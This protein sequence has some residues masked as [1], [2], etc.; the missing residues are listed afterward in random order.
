MEEYEDM[1]EYYKQNA[2]II[3]KYSADEAKEMLT[4]QQAIEELH[5][6]GFD[7]FEIT[8]DYKADGEYV[9]D[10][11]VTGSKEQR[12][13]YQTYYSSLV[14]EE[15]WYI[16]MINGFITASPAY[17]NS[18]LYVPVIL[19]E[20]ESILGYDSDTNTFFEIIPNETIAKLKVVNKINAET[21][22]SFTNEIL[23]E[24]L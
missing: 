1:E 18:K 5:K 19:S 24:L 16:I 22:D 11:E 6:R 4:E 14:N 23:L 7:Q 12:P 9:G 21:L 8:Y 17:F 10:A 13:M 3:K 2:T 20:T 15:V